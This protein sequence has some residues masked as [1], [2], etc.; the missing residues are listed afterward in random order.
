MEYGAGIFSNMFEH[1]YVRQ[2]STPFL[3][4]KAAFD[5]IAPI[6]RA[7]ALNISRPLV[8]LKK[9]IKHVFVIVLESVRADA[10]PLNETFAKAI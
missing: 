6:I 5:S 2:L 8:T 1:Y 4:Q 10:L 9:P 3:K 7:P